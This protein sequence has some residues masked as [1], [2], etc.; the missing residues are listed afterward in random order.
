MTLKPVRILKLGQEDGK[1]GLRRSA[2]FGIFSCCVFCCYLFLP[3]L[4]TGLVVKVVF[5]VRYQPTF[6]LS[7]VAKGPK[8]TIEFLLVNKII[9]LNV[10]RNNTHSSGRNIPT[11]S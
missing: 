10:L 8:I 4:H 11:C 9:I 1:S 7:T 6:F 5:R 2:S 3:P